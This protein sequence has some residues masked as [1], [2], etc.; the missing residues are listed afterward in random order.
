MVLRYA[1]RIRS[2]DHRRSSCQASAASLS[3]RLIVRSRFVY[4]FLTNCC[5]M[6]DPPWTTFLFRT[7]AQTARMIP[8]KSTPRCSQKRR[9]STDTMA[10]FITGAISF[11]LTTT[12]LSSPWRTA[13]TVLPSE[14]SEEHTSELQSRENL[15]CRLLLEKK[16]KT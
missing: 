10:C 9:S 6:V 14:R 11:E 15:V 7:S 12:R 3:L 8:L 1:V 2:F 16:K 4:V 13:S 5:V